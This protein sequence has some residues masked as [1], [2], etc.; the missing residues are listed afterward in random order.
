MIRWDEIRWDKIRWDETGEIGL[1]LNILIKDTM[2]IS[3]N[4]YIIWDKII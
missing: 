1:T 2:S 4:I 3:Y